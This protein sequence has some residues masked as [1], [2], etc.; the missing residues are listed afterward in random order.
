MQFQQ[1]RLKH[2][3]GKLVVISTSLLIIHG[4]GKELAELSSGIVNRCTY[5]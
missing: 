1:N 5:I 2:E 4:K 3:A